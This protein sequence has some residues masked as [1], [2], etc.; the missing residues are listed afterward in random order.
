MTVTKMER[1]RFWTRLGSKSYGKQQ[2]K[3]F[4]MRCLVSPEK[5][6]DPQKDAADGYCLI[7]EVIG[8][9]VYS[10]FKWIE[11]TDILSKENAIK[12]KKIRREQGE[13]KEYFD[14]RFLSDPSLSVIGLQKTVNKIKTQIKRKI[15]GG[16]NSNRYKK[17]IALF[18]TG[19]LVV[20]VSVT[21][22]NPL[23]NFSQIEVHKS[24]L[25]KLFVEEINKYILEQLGK[26][27]CPFDEIEIIFLLSQPHGES[28]LKK[29]SSK[30]LSKWLWDQRPNSF[31]QSFRKN[32]TKEAINKLKRNGR[33][34]RVTWSLCWPKYKNI[35]D[36][37]YEQVKFERMGKPQLG[38]FGNAGLFTHTR[39]YTA[40]F[41]VVLIFLIALVINFLKWIFPQKVHFVPEI[42]GNRLADIYLR[43]F[44]YDN[45]KAK[46]F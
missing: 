41:F 26:R 8:G 30:D 28:W 4:R 36:M 31:F 29:M 34:K 22:L 10:I 45:L 12:I 32:F 46:P 13:K 5:I 21:Y 43:I 18:G 27:H 25:N 3:Y 42:I 20:G 38:P 14:R 39:S 2:S 1:E 19:K 6:N 11:V 37:T 35:A 17:R 7:T 9:K 40:I 33:V 23:P 44:P 16:N 24:I 15:D